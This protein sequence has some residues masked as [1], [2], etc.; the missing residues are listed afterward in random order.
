MAIEATEQEQGAADDYDGDAMASLEDVLGEAPD[1]TPPEGEAEASGAKIPEAPAGEPK[2]TEAGQEPQAKRSLLDAARSI[3]E[4]RGSGKPPAE[5]PAQ[6]SAQPTAESV[7][8]AMRKEEDFRAQLEQL[9]RDPAGWIAEHGS[10][11]GVDSAKVLE[12]LTTHH[13]SPEAFRAKLEADGASSELSERLKAIEERQAAQTEREREEAEA[14]ERKGQL[15]A[16]Q[17]AVVQFTDLTGQKD[18]EG[19]DAPLRYPLFGKL[20]PESRGLFGE[21]VGT[22]FQ[23]LAHR[24]KAEGRTVESPQS[25]DEIADLLESQMAEMRDA[26]GVATPRTSAKRTPRTLTGA[27]ASET[28]SAL[29][30]ETDE[31]YASAALSVLDSLM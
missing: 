20:K 15:D 18:G 27:D 17:Q 23:V 28:A 3:R 31:E 11:H 22:Y 6:P 25:L 19:E 30:P 16:A 24:A 8:R 7:V 12:N 2:K 13:L 4:S 14:R 21:M 29:N 10:K 1:G 26:W 5:T 9:Q